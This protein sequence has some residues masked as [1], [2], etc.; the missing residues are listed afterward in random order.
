MLRRRG[1]GLEE[2]KSYSRTHKTNETSGKSIR[3]PYRHPPPPRTF[4]VPRPTPCILGPRPP[5]GAVGLN[6]PLGE[7]IVWKKRIMTASMRQNASAAASTGFRR[8]AI[9]PPDSPLVLLFA[10]LQSVSDRCMLPSGAIYVI[11]FS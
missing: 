2:T 6:P 9:T 7:K 5:F 4:I 11:L 1:C 8:I 10:S 3:L